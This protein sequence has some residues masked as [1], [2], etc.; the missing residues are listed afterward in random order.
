LRTFRE[1]PIRDAI[2]ILGKS[3]GTKPENLQLHARVG[4]AAALWH[5][6]PE[7]RPEVFY[8]PADFAPGGT[9]DADAVRSLLTRRYRVPEARV[10]TRRIS[11]CTHREARGLRDL[12]AERGTGRLTA[13]THAYHAA[14]TARYLEEVLPGRTRVVRVTAA[15]LA[16]VRP[17]GDAAPPFEELPALI[18]ASLP[19]GWDAAREA[20]VEAAMTVLHALDR[21]GRVEA[22][23]ADRMRNPPPG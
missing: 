21:S 7:P 2:A 12:C 10:V 9:P 5:A 22:A 6:A 15:E 19:R 17:P 11:N 14:R 13:V 18:E 20:M 16:K 1:G 3:Q 23:L 4:L 8:V